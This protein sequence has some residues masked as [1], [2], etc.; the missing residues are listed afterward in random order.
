MAFILLVH[1]PRRPNTLENRSI[2]TNRIFNEDFLMFCFI[3]YL[4]TVQL[5][6]KIWGTY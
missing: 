6:H 2:C 1:V 3:L 4:E 5:S